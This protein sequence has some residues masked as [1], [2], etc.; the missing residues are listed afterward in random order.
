MPVVT[1]ADDLVQA[2]MDKIEK[3]SP[4]S[5]VASYVREVLYNHLGIKQKKNDKKSLQNKRNKM[6]YQLYMEGQTAGAISEVFGVSARTVYRIV[7][8]HS[9]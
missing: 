8:E 2:I 1:L 9:A 5:T 6:I 4:G 3:D 7:S